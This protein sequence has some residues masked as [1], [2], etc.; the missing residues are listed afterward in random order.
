MVLPPL[1]NSPDSQNIH[2]D[3]AKI[4]NISETSKYFDFF[5]ILQ[6]VSIQNF[7]EAPCNSHHPFKR[8]ASAIVI[9]IVSPP[10]KRFVETRLVDVPHRVL[11]IRFVHLLGHHP[12][13][14]GIEAIEV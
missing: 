12:P 2:F 4:D 13:D 6:P 8:F 5:F 7:L 10:V 11:L 1:G 3:I 9:W 14:E